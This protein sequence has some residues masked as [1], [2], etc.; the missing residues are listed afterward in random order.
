VRY[1]LPA[2][3]LLVLLLLAVQVAGSEETPIGTGLEASDALDVR[4]DVNVRGPAAERIGL[5]LDR[6]QTK[7][8]LKLRLAGLRPTYE[9]EGDGTLF[10]DVGVM[11]SGFGVSLEYWRVVYYYLQDGR[12]FRTSAI[13]WSDGG[14][15]SHVDDPEFILQK[16][17]EHMDEFVNDYLAANEH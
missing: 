10:I 12:A 5:A 17:D 14:T 6:V 8:E 2:S 3:T 11:D 15:G 13:A 4:V 9:Y 16:L 1:F 7:V